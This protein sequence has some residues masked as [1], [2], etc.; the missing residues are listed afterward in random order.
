MCRSR[1]IGDAFRVRAI[2]SQCLMWSA[3]ETTSPQRSAAAWTS[4]CAASPVG[5]RNRP[6]QAGCR[7][8]VGSSQTRLAEGECSN[9]PLL[10]RC[11]SRYDE[12]N[13]AIISRWTNRSGAG[14]GVFSRKR[15]PLP[16][17]PDDSVLSI[18][19]I[20]LNRAQVV[21]RRFSSGRTLRL[22]T[23]AMLNGNRCIR[24]EIDACG[25]YDQN[26]A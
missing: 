10:G 6:T 23:A 3:D 14:R 22:F 15:G 21:R 24:V 13:S 18:T 19:P 7:E 25:G 1:V 16:S 11:A 26:A 9:E 2:D 8:P 17:P 20:G 5:C 4:E 12:G